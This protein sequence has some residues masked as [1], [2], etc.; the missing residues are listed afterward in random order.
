[1]K[2]VI[3]LVGRPNVGKSTLFNVLTQTRNALVADFPGLT[4]DRQYGDGKLGGHA[5][6]VVDTGGLTPEKEGVDV[7]MA[8]QV[9]QAIQEADAVCFLVDAK[10]GVTAMDQEVAKQLRRYGR[11]VFLVANKIDGLN[12]DAALPELYSL[13]LGE[14]LPIAA[15]Q[16]R[17]VQQLVE[18]L[19][20]VMQ[21]PPADDEEA[22]DDAIRVAVIGRPNVGKSTLVNRLLGEERVVVFD[23]PG[24]TRDSVFI[25]FSRQLEG[26]ESRDFV[27]I[28]TAGVRRRSKVSE[29]VE[30]FSVIKTIQAIDAANVVF[31]V[32]DASET[33]TE[34]DLSLLRLILERGRALVFVVNKWDNLSAEQKE[35]I[36]T[37]LDRRLRFI[38]FARTHMISALHGTGV[39]LLLDTAIEAYN[40][41][42]MDV[43]TSKLNQILEDAL[44]EL[45][46]PLA[47]GRRIKIRYVHQG[48]KNPPRLVLHGNQLDRLPE[49]Y[50]RYL[51]RY[52]Q[53]RLKIVGSPVQLDFKTSDNPYKH[54]RN[55]LTPR[56]EYKR[57]RM[58]KHLKSGK[59]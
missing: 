59:K 46:P 7:L 10:A 34:Q 4:R 39:G 36:K 23:E 35:R 25:P 21:L 12:L 33:I 2:P 30:K 47:R 37:D 19:F 44:M 1:M 51:S 15:S 5:Y 50:V 58:L 38:D 27:L 57:K 49:N 24:T 16:S 6:L 18:H 11:K 17:G 22:I 31:Q 41:A 40:S 26:H 43:S 14:P 8:Q 9:E 28:D 55:K 29:T 32:I 53:K 54:K 20:Q 56:Q 13:G 52:F 3:A 42:M 48:G 45:Q